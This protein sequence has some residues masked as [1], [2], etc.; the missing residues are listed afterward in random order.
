VSDGVRRHIE[1]PREGPA[2]DAAECE[3]EM[4]AVEFLHIDIN[5]QQLYIYL[6]SMYHSVG[7]PL[8]NKK[9]VFDNTFTNLVDH[10]F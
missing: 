1:A 4:R 3:A 9:S 7:A 10:V 2:I 8:S 6:F 5:T